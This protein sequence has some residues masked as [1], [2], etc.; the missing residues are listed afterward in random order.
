M[1]LDV[2]F[3]APILAILLLCLRLLWVLW[4]CGWRVWSAPTKSLGGYGY[5]A[6]NM[7]KPPYAGGFLFE[8]GGLVGRFRREVG[9]Y[10]L[11]DLGGTVGVLGECAP[12]HSGFHEAEAL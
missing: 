1:R 3:A 11:H 5:R 7:E 2:P 9:F 10:V 4:R 6:W 12:E 8:G